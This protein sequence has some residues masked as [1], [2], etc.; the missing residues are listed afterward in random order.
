MN[1]NLLDHKIQFQYISQSL[2]H[3][4]TFVNPLKC[5]IKLVFLFVNK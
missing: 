2:F 5:C 4:V 1:Y 3:N